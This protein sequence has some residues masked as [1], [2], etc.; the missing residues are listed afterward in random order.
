MK[1]LLVLAGIAASLLVAAPAAFADS[2]DHR[3]HDRHDRSDRWDRSDRHDRGDRWDRGDRRDWRHGH[4]DHRSAY[5]H[6]HRRDF[7]HWRPY[8]A[9]YNYHSF[10]RPV[11]SDYYYTVPARDR[12]GR[13]ILL[14]VNA[15]TGQVISVR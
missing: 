4:F 12:Y 10:G 2:R 15:Y 9:R 5:R 3:G 7:G 1:K 13:P 8:M 11:F 14:T 6:M